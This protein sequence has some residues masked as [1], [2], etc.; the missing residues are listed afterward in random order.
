MKR[1]KWLLAGGVNRTF[2]GIKD[3]EAQTFGVAVG[4][5][6]LHLGPLAGVFWGPCG[7]ETTPGERLI[8]TN[9]SLMIHM[10]DISVLRCWQWNGGIYKWKW[11]QVNTDIKVNTQNQNSPCLRS[12]R[13]NKTGFLHNLSSKCSIC[14]QEIAATEK[15]AFIQ[16]TSSESHESWRYLHNVLKTL[17]IGFSETF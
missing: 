11:V 10:C 3:E 15:Q 2:R 13:A 4:K 14:F 1:S 5:Q 12:Q 17:F 6:K 9:S 16:R 8:W 7:A